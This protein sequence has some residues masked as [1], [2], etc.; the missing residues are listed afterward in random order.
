MTGAFTAENFIA[1]L[2]DIDPTISYSIIPL[3]GGL[4]NSTVRAVKKPGSPQGSGSFPNEQSIILKHVPPFV[5]SIGEKA[6][7]SVYRQVVE[8]RALEI[9]AKAPAIQEAQ[10]EC[11][12]FVPSVLYR[13]DI[14]HDLVIT[15]L[16]DDLYTI[17]R[18][19]DY[20]QTN[21]VQEVASIGRRLGI[22]LAKLHT[23][24][25]LNQP[26]KAWK[27]PK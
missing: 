24:L 26:F 13:D 21:T 16:G 2:H 7:F 11:Q 1:F 20:N 17:D 14:R 6:P 10:R 18:W 19:F 23:P 9:L 5:A 8:A 15:D 4:I 27:T 22:F 12:V 3:S 25:Y